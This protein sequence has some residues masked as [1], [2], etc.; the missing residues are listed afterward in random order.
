VIIDEALMIPMDLFGVLF[1]AID[2]NKVKRFILVGDP[3]QLP[4]IG[5]GRPFVDIVSWLKA[6]DETV[7][8]LY[9]KEF[10]IS[11][12]ERRACFAQLT[13]R[14]RFEEFNS[15]GLQLSDCYLSEDPVPGDDELLSKVARQ[16]VDGDL[17]VCFW[18]DDQELDELLASQ[19]K[20]TLGLADEKDYKSFNESLGISNDR[21]RRHDPCRAE[22]WQ[23]LSPVR[24]HEFGTIEINRKIQACYRGGLIRNAR[25][26]R[27]KNKAPRPFGENE[28]V[29][30]D[31]VIQAVNRRRKAW[32]RGSG[33][34]YVANGEIGLVI[35]TDR[36]YDC[37]D[38]AY[39]T[40]P[41]VSYRYS[42]GEVD[43]NLD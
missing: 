21:D 24:N 12:E 36:K 43:D 42:W 38:V 28:L 17:D 37:I 26:P 40:Q 20:Q 7:Q 8:K 15:L 4:P 11:A 13:E 31:K 6:D 2:L 16:D 25:N 18:H 41:E 30:N 23:I 19:L 27:S 22:H 29:M 10:Q 33:F 34:N 39:S 1:R 9:P 3:N 35:R 32:P 5:P 14:A